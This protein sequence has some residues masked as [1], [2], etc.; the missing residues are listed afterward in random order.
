MCKE[1]IEPAILC[2]NPIH[3]EKKQPRKKPRPFD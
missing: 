3:F 2:G 1:F